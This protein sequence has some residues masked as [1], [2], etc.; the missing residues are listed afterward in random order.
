MKKHLFLP[1][2]FTFVFSINIF[3]Q[4]NDAGKFNAWTSASFSRKNNASKKT[5]Y[6]REV[7][8]GRNQ[9]F[10]RVVFEFT[11]DIPRYQIEYIEPPIVGTA[12]EEVKVKGKFFVSINLQSLPYPDDE[13]L[14]E[15]RMPTDYKN[16]YSLAEI[17]QIEWFEGTR[18]YVIG[19]KAK[20]M[21]RVQQLK[22]PA[23][24][25]I[26]FKNQ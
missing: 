10:D 19:L 25:V 22:N 8:T 13:K 20:K 21:F 26:D 1:I 17:T 5:P 4:W 6:L 18:W 14:G 3:A 11:G 23:R 16:A 12:D 15:V 7:R 24:L 9:G 2:V